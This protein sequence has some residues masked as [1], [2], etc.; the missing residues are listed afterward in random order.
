MPIRPLVQ[1]RHAPRGGEGRGTSMRRHLPRLATAAVVVALLS[2][3]LSLFF[4][5]DLLAQREDVVSRPGRRC[6]APARRVRRRQRGA[7]R[8]CRPPGRSSPP[9]SGPEGADAARRGARCDWQHAS[10]TAVLAARMAATDRRIRA[11]R[12]RGGS[13]GGAVCRCRVGRRFRLPTGA[14]RRA[15]RGRVRLGRARPAS[16][17]LRQG[18]PRHRRRT[19]ERGGFAEARSVPAPVPG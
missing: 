19:R 9:L 10:R 15:H 16:L 11:A 2:L 6:R 7:R 12:R 13:A 8:G 14:W 4:L 18:E 3:E 5:G 17:D 1:A